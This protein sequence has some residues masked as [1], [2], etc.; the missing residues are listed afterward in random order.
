MLQKDVESGKWGEERGTAVRALRKDRRC[1]QE[2][3]MGQRLLEP[4]EL[5][6][7]WSSSRTEGGRP[8]I[9]FAPLSGN[10]RDGSWA[11]SVLGEG[12]TME[13]LLS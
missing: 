11:M 10:A 8:G 2:G 5:E 1:R 13:L 9:W 7:D 6:S 3:S 12:C 4:E